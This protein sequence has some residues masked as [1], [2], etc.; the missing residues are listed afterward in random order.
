MRGRDEAVEE[1]R[2]VVRPLVAHLDGERLAAVGAR[3]LDPAV[4]VKRGAIKPQIMKAI[5][6]TSMPPSTASLPE[7]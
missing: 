4:G 1:E 5:A 6:V 7:A 3:R 2:L